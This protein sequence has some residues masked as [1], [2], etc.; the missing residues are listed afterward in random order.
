M[1]TADGNEPTEAQWERFA[2]ITDGERERDEEN[3]YD[4][5]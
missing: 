3:I 1:I 5:L 4:K 2:E